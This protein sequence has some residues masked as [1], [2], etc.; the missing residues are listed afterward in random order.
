MFSFLLDRKKAFEDV[1]QRSGHGSE[2]NKQKHL[3][4]ID[5]G[6]SPAQK[7][8]TASGSKPSVKPTTLTK[9][10]SNLG[11]HSTRYKS[12]NLEDDTL[13]ECKLVSDKAVSLQHKVSSS[14]THYC[15]CVHTLVMT[16]RK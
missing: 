8:K 5:T 6:H 12:K 13:I 11:G 16:K 10:D 3:E 14:L 15:K 1:I 9:S 4:A 2:F 7:P